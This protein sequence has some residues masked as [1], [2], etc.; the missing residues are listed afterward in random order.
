VIRSV[1]RLVA[2]NPILVAQAMASASGAYAVLAGAV[3]LDPGQFVR[4]SLLILLT[5]V[6]A[7][8]VQAFLYQA[9][10]VRMRADKF[11]HVRSAHVVVAATLSAC[12]FA[13]GACLIG[14]SGGLWIVCLAIASTGPVWSEWMRHRAMALDRRHALVVA[15][16][17]RLLL[18]LFAPIV[19]AKT[20]MVEP[21]F[22]AVGVAWSVP[23]VV[24]V[25]LLPRIHRFTPRREYLPSSG[26]ILTDFL[27]GQLIPAVPLL[28]LGGLGPSLYLGGV[29]LAQTILGP[30]NLVF[31]AF[32]VSLA[33][34]GVNRDS[35]AGTALI[36]HGRVL[37]RRLGTFTG[38]LVPTAVVAVWVTGYGFK[39]VTSYALL[40]GLMLVGILT[41]MG[42]FSSIDTIVL[43]LLG[44]NGLVAGG[45]VV[46]GAVTAA[47]FTVGY[48]VNGV[49][50]ALICGFIVAAIANPLVFVLPA[51]AVYRKLLTKGAEPPA[52]DEP[53]NEARVQPIG[54]DDGESA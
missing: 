38:I 24:L 40:V 19:L 30:L 25:V 47:A 6:C 16:G 21:Y 46:L 26:Q 51:R 36:A 18:T 43:H 37:A 17:A 44:R 9:S 27:V 50:G 45:R 15:D 7:G 13:A 53:R 35:H 54:V 11:A 52:E 1:W 49:D 42:G 48:F 2:N 12:V 22:I 10:L 23:Y 39:G 29:R 14:G 8:A 41:V 4:F 28:V 33:T 5:Q 31:A 32:T 3:W 34:D 20:E